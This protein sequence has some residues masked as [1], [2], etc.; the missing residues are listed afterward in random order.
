MR[1]TAWLV[2]AALLAA[3]APA[4]AAPRKHPTKAKREA[5]AK[6]PAATVPRPGPYRELLVEK[7][8]FGTSAWWD[9]MLREN[10][11]TCCN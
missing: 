3:A 11:L 10:R 9:Q 8:P 6:R 5:P 1:T 2:C 4:D 7:T